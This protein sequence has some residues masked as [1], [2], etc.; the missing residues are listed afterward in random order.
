MYRIPISFIH[1]IGKEDENKDLIPELLRIIHRY[2][3]LI[4]DGIRNHLDIERK[5][6]ENLLQAISNLDLTPSSSKPIISEV[7]ESSTS[8]E[9]KIIVYEKYFSIGGSAMGYETFEEINQKEPTGIYYC[10]TG[11][12]D[13]E[14]SMDTVSL[15]KKRKY[16]FITNPWDLDKLFG[17]MILLDAS[18]GIFVQRLNFDVRMDVYDLD[19]EAWSKLKLK[20]D[21]IVDMMDGFKKN[22]ELGIELFEKFL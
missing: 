16:R 5:Q 3:P 13:K 6:S 21:G 18:K 9:V 7:R 22:P 4:L 1:T 17:C 12:F 15:T 2:N 19:K 11:K 10:L 8:D 20:L 14:R